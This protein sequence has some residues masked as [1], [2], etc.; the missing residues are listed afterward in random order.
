[1]KKFLIVL[2]V[3]AMAS[4][5]FVGCLGVTPDEDVAVTLAAI[6]GVTAPVTGA[7]PVTTITATAQYTGVVTWLSADTTFAAATAYTATITLTEKAG[8]TLTGVAADYFT[9]TGATAT[10][11]ADSGVVTAVFPATAVA[12]EPVLE[13]TGIAVL[14]KTM[15]FTYEEDDEQIVS[16]TATYELKGYD[17]DIIDFDECLFLTSDSKVATVSDAGLVTSKGEGTANIL[18]S[19]TAGE[20]TKR[21]TIEVTVTRVPM[22]ITAVMPIFTAGTAKDFTIV[23]EAN[24]DLN[25]TVLSYFT[26]P[27]G[28]EITYY[29]STWEG[30]TEI[31]FGV[32]D[33][34]YTLEDTVDSN[35]NAEFTTSGFYST[36]L[37][38]WEVT[39]T[40]TYDDP[41]VKDVLLCSKVILAVVE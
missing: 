1:M 20:I 41:I 14:P 24:G 34:G 9:V 13:F 8:Y 4:F 30:P 36:T 3:V 19:Y 31:V 35:F 18:V 5:L 11:A 25:K 33:T 40:G 10:N 32:P 16:V 21:D 15:D 37:E 28:V 39:G 38:V 27:A 7:T 26:V 22:E 29:G 17:V 2:T 6:P 12:S 23:T